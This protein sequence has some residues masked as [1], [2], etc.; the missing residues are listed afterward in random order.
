M[1]TNFK[2]FKLKPN[3]KEPSYEWSKGKEKHNKGVHINKHMWMKRTENELE[4]VGCGIPC[5]KLNN[6]IVIDLDF[7]VKNTDEHPYDKSKCIFTQEFGEVL[8]YAKKHNIFCVKTPSGGFHLYFKYDPEIKQTS[9][10]SVHIDVRNDGGYIVAPWTKIDGKQ[11]KVIHLGKI[12]KCPAELKT[13]MLDKVFDKQTIKRIIFKNKKEKKQQQEH[14]DNFLDSYDFDFPEELLVKVIEHLPDKFF[15]EHEHWLKFTTAMKTLDRDDL[16]DIWSEKR[17]GKSYNEEKNNEIWDG[18]QDHY[19]LFCVNHILLEAQQ[20]GME[21]ARI[22]LDYYKYK[23]IPQMKTKPDEVI[24]RE[25]LGYDFFQGISEKLI[26]V[27]SDTGT[28]KTTSFKIYIKKTDQRFISSVSRVSLGKEQTRVFREA[29]IDC[30]FHQEIT[31]EIKEDPYGGWFRYEGSNIVITIDSLLKLNNWSD[32]Q[33]YTLYL[34]EINS[35]LE[36]MIRA[37]MKTLGENRVSIYDLL[38]SIIHQSDKVIMT[39]ADINDI[40]FDF[41]KKLLKED[42]NCDMRYIENQYKHNN[43]KEATEMND[44]EELQKEVLTLDKVMICSDSKTKVDVLAEEFKKLGKEYMLYTS[45][46]YFH[47]KD[48]KITKYKE[49][50]SLDLC[51]IVLFSPAVVYG[52]DSS[53]KRP[54]YGIFG[55]KTISPEAMNQQLNRCRNIEYFKFIFEGKKWKAYNYK[56]PNDTYRELIETE[57]YGLNIKKEIYDDYSSKTINIQNDDYLKLLAK[58]IY[59]DDCYSTNM[60]AHL[61]NILKCKGFKVKC[62]YKQTKKIDV[63][64]QKAEIENQ[65]YE[66]VLDEVEKFIEFMDQQ[67]LPETEEKQMHH[68]VCPIEYYGIELNDHFE[69]PYCNVVYYTTKMPPEDFHLFE[70]LMKNNHLL[71][72]HRLYCQYFHKEETDILDNFEK[73]KDF[74]IQK[75]TMFDNK[76]LFLIKFKAKCKCQS[77]QDIMAVCGLNEATAQN[78][79]DEYINLFRCQRKKS[80]FNLT[81]PADCSRLIF[82][83]YKQLFGS[84]CVGQSRSRKGGV[85]KQ[86]YSMKDDFVEEQERIRKYKDDYLERQQK[87]YD[88]IDAQIDSESEEESDSE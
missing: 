63:K 1:L 8:D 48:G 67:K 86:L 19:K 66:E 49:I 25:K 30:H 9:Q 82:N 21:N 46:G 52:L 65:K 81:D 43:G 85:S 58:Y 5:G 26:I 54:V 41:I 50:P 3:S 32:Y 15:T 39:D 62:F 2:S 7:Y 72:E 42:P 73:N 83:M 16:W 71:T 53:M 38:K 37:D 57:K 10:K 17:G 47:N 24:N 29:D 34:D 27:K 31:D 28:G 74:L 61:I 6:I 35:L 69:N 23:P 45:E 60:F 84:K 55:G 44:Y 18:I 75:I 33:G 78:T 87:R 59:R 14:L 13:F 80:K 51:E 4:E 12:A 20:N 56:T 11:Y 77:K 64:A 88:W 79:Y 22:L 70:D 76:L 40:T 68:Q 36:Y